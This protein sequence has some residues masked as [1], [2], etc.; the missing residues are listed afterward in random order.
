MVFFQLIDLYWTLIPAM[1]GFYFWTHPASHY[2]ASRA[3]LSLF[4]IHLWSVRL[5]HSYLRR[6]EYQLGVREDWRYNR[7]ARDFPQHWWWLSFL[8]VYLFQQVLLVGITLPFYAIFS[9]TLATNAWD[10]LA[11]FVCLVGITI[12]YFADTQLYVFMKDN[13][14]RVEKGMQRIGVLNS[15]LWYYS[16]HPNYFGEQVFWWGFSIFAWNLNQLWM[17]AG[18][19]INSCCLAIVTVMVEKRMR[20]RKERS[21]EL[22]QY[23]AA[24]SVL[25][26]WFKSGNQLDGQ[27]VE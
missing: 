24:T 10:I 26:P 1:V 12:G 2:D 9:S 11:A 6:E 15:G 4:L 5:T 22:E 7:I 3:W 16:R 17:V 23:I 8:V 27:K 25:I 20:Q 21:K 13:E 14:E 19:F 18:T